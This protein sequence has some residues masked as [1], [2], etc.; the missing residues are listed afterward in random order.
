VEPLK[1]DRSNTPQQRPRDRP[2]TGKP[3]ASS[4]VGPQP[5]A[6]NE[7]NPLQYLDEERA[8]QEQAIK[9]I[10]MLKE[11]FLGQ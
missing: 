8:R 10:G 11:A 2:K 7:F 5:Q 3:Q 1:K 9:G 6:N 4:F